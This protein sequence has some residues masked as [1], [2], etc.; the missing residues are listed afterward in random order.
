[1]PEH[2]RSWGFR[3]SITDG[4]VIAAA[5][6][7]TWLLWPVIG[8][9]AGVIPMAVGHFFLFCNVFRIHRW[10]ELTWAGVCLL[11]VSAWAGCDHLSWLGIM[12]VQTPLTIALIWTEMR[13]PRY[14]GILA[15]RL[16][17]GLQDYL[18]GR[19]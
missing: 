17:P 18:E 10:K 8:A 19:L 5:I 3:F 9:M 13:Q 11:N 14:H 4:L 6:P 16:N 7:A 2:P 12:T 15:P 1:M